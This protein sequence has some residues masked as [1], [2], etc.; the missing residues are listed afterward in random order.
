LRRSTP[1]YTLRTNAQLEDRVYSLV[2]ALDRDR[3]GAA[4]ARPAQER[5]RIETAYWTLVVATI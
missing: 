1:E 5:L 4:L 3:S 2:T